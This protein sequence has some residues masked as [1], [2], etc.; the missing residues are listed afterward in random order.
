MRCRYSLLASLLS[1]LSPSSTGALK[2]FRELRLR[3][4]ERLRR[5]LRLR[6]GEHLAAEGGH[7]AGLMTVI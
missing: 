4:G 7:A 2:A 5:Q 1:S 6:L 3:L